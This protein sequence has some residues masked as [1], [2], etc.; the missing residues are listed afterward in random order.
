MSRATSGSRGE[1]RPRIVDLLSP[2]NGALQGLASQTRV[3]GVT[4]RRSTDC[5]PTRERSSPCYAQQEVYHIS[6]PLTAARQRGANRLVCQFPS[7]AN[8]ETGAPR[9]RLGAPLR[10][11][12][13]IPIKRRTIPTNGTPLHP[14]LHPQQRTHQSLISSSPPYPPRFVNQV[15]NRRF[16]G[17]RSGIAMSCAACVIEQARERGM[18]MYVS[19]KDE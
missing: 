15:L 9:L 7:Q 19:H 16:P 4:I 11:P 6:A 18:Y 17:C 2:R 8:G 5:D 14:D 10:S 13:L 1:R 12:T 3:R